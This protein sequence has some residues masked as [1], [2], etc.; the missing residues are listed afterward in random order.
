MPTN[1]SVNKA[2]VLHPVDALQLERDVLGKDISDAA[3]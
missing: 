3:R 1:R 2:S